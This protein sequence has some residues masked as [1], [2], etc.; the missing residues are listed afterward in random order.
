MS[1][2]FLG[3]VLGALSRAFDASERSD[4]RLSA[5]REARA[6]GGYRCE[7]LVRDKKGRRHTIELRAMTVHEA[8]A[9]ARVKGLEVLGA[10]FAPDWQTVEDVA[11]LDRASDPKWRESAEREL[12]A[13]HR[14][15]PFGL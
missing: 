1:D 6:A 8:A 3:G 11:Q 10:S 7:L 13:D 9:K 14:G 12:G 5:S 2:G 4:R 15:L